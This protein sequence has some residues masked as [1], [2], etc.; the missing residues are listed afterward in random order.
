M[1]GLLGADAE[2]LL[3]PAVTTTEL[4]ESVGLPLATLNSWIQAG[5][6][7]PSIAAGAGQRIPRYWSAQDLVTVRTVA[8]LRQAGRPLL[9][10]TEIADWIKAAWKVDW[11][12]QVLVWDGA[13]VR[14]LGAAQLSLPATSPVHNVIHIL[15]LPIGFWRIDAERRAVQAVDVA[16]LRARRPPSRAHIPKLHGRPP[17][18]PLAGQG[19]L[20]FSDQ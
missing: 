3:V 9:E 7:R 11:P 8:A 13:G 2:P 12:D 6:I 14:L 20:P 4:R 16:A 1:G 10:L 15:S 18:G 19:T 17:P 5:V